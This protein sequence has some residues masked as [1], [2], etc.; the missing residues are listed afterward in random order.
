VIIKENIYFLSED[1][2]WE[3][4]YRVPAHD[5]GVTAVSWCP[6][7]KLDDISHVTPDAQLSS[8]FATSSQD[9]K[10]KVWVY[11]NGT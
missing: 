5:M 3:K 8:K 2:T 1:D 10:T 11:N 6:L 7:L 4:P 9:N